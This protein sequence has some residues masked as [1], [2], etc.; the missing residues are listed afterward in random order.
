VRICIITFQWK[1][2]TRKNLSLVAVQIYTLN[3]GSVRRQFTKSCQSKRKEI[4]TIVYGKRYL[5]FWNKFEK[6][7]AFTS[8][9]IHGITLICIRFSIIFNNLRLAYYCILLCFLVWHIYRSL[10]KQKDRIQRENMYYNMSMEASHQE[11]PQSGSSTDIDVKSRQCETT[12]YEKLSEQMKGN[13]YDRKRHLCFW[14]KFWKTKCCK[15]C[16]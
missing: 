4:Y 3:R 7:N 8:A 1:L 10:L 15:F 2:H 9:I 14:N 16:N 6:Q 5:C 13:V 11:E 12:I